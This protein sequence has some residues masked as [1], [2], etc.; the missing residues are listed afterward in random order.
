MFDKDLFEWTDLER[1]FVKKM[2]KPWIVKVEFGYMNPDRDV[3]LTDKDWKAKTY[4]IKKNSSDTHVAFEYMYNN[5]PSWV[6]NT[7]ADY[8][9]YY[10]QDKFH[11]QTRWKFLERFIDSHKWKTSW[12]DKEQSDLYVMESAVADMLREWTL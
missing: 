11:R 5:K 7:K 12:W 8:I 6:L 10:Y 4:E 3:R 2:L 9:V 1:E